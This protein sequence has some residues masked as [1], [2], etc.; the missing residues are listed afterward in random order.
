MLLFQ[1]IRGQDSHRGGE[2]GDRAGPPAPQGLET[3]WYMDNGD[4]QGHMQKGW[5][6]SPASWALTPVQPSKGNPERFPSLFLQMK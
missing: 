6:R 4:A 1:A 5:W 3:G 2:R